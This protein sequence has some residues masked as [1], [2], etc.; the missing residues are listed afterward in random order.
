MR[1]CRVIPGT[2]HA[3]ATDA[4]SCRF[5]LLR[6]LVSSV[7]QPPPNVKARSVKNGDVPRACHPRTRGIGSFSFSRSTRL[8]DS[9]VHLHAV[10]SPVGVAVLGHGAGGGVESPDLVG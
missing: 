10:D 4:Q 7:A 8:M 2:P 6:C 3:A 5:A 9:R 1:R